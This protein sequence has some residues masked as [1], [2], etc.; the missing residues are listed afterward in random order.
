MMSEAELEQRVDETIQLYEQVTGSAATRTRGMIDR[1]GVVEALSRLM[2]SPDLQRGFRALRDND[3]LEETFEAVVTR[4]PALFSAE[5][6]EAARWR[7][8][9]PHGLL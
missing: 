3:Q 8:D 6:V 5:V 7:L 1:H 9:N 4:S 2:L